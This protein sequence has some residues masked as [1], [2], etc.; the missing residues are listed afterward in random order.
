[1]WLLTGDDLGYVKYWQS[2]MNNVQMYQAHKDQAIRCARYDKFRWS[3][4]VALFR[5]VTEEI[6]SSYFTREKYKV[7]RNYCRIMKLHMSILRFLM[8]C[9]I[10]H[11]G[12][13]N[14]GMLYTLCFEPWCLTCTFC[15]AT[16]ILTKYLVICFYESIIMISLK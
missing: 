5:I 11:V 14:I 3:D 15:T 4:I 13:L 8:D 12:I 16:L 10:F 7:D 2:N 9:I 1:M 6:I